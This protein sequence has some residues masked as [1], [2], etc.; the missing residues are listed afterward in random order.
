MSFVPSFIFIS[1]RFIRITP[2]LAP[3]TPSCRHFQQSIRLKATHFDRIH[4]HSTHHTH[5]NTSCVTICRVSIELLISFFLLLLLLLHMCRFSGISFIAC[6]SN[7]FHRSIAIISLNRIVFMPS[8]KCLSSQSVVD[9][10]ERERE[11]IL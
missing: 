8:A 7:K 9:G 2:S 5:D 11:R 4:P 6:E 3:S 1:F 10:A